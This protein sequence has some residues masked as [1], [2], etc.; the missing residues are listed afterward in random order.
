M[1]MPRLHDDWILIIRR[2]WSI[3]FLLLAGVL[4]AVVVFLQFD[5]PYSRYSPLWF[6]L[7]ACAATFGAFISR[8]ISQSAFRKPDDAPANKA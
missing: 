1:T 7:A 4:Q 6:A 3:R 5:Q 8:L 2:A